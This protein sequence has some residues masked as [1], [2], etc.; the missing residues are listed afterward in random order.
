M[1]QVGAVGDLAQVTEGGVAEGA[2]QR[3][4]LGGD[5]AEDD[6][7]HTQGEEEEA[8]FEQGG[9]G[10]GH[11]PAEDH[12]G[13]QGQPAGGLQRRPQRS[14]GDLPGGDGPDAQSPP[15]VEIAA[16]RSRTYGSGGSRRRVCPLDGR[17]V[18]GGR[19]RQGRAVLGPH[20]HP[21]GQG[22]PDQDVLTAGVGPLVE[23]HDRRP[24]L[25]GESH[26]DGRGD[27]SDD[28]HGQNR[29]QAPRRA[30]LPPQVEQNQH[31]RRPHDVE[32]LLDGKA[33]HVLEHRRLSGGGE[34]VA[35]S[36]D[37]VP[38]GHVEQR[39][40][41][42]EAQAGELAGA[43]EYLDEDGHSHQHHQEGGQE[44]TGPAGPELAQADGQAPRPL[45]K[46]QG[47]DQEARQDEEDVHAEEAPA[48]H[49]RATVV[50]HHAEHGHGPQAVQRRDVAEHDGA[51]PAPAGVER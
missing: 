37:E 15:A 22:C 2:G 5:H 39:G 1:P 33:P 48:G 19:G 40:Q 14:G 30:E 25:V 8:P 21:D 7:G 51:T 23:T 27:G 45:T 32:L 10:P 26:V 42:V 31:D 36:H 43:G 47:G 20:G 38:V 41:R 17:P 50:E 9:S 49:R 28:G 29:P 24:A 46:E 16:V 12:A 11:S 34:V 6:H 4:P 13:H 44:A 18:E 35:P 3:V